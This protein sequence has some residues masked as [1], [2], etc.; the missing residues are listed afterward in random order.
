MSKPR[1][2]A[3]TS[4][5]QPVGDDVKVEV[6]LSGDQGRGNTGSACGYNWG[7][8]ALKSREIIAYRVIKE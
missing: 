4:G 7:Q 2:I 5:K 3:H 1:Y 8:T 6:L